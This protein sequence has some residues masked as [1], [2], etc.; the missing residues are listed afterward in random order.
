MDLTLTEDQELVQRTA[1]EFL[2]SRCTMAHVREMEEDPKGYSPE[3]WK[4]MVELGWMGLALPEEYGG[5]GAGFLEVCLL[6]E[7]MGRC[8]LPSPFVPTVACCGMAVARFGTEDQKGA[9]LGAIARGRVMTYARA[10]PHGR[11]AS[12]G[13][14]VSA[15]ETDGGFVLEGTAL[16]VPYAHV[17]ADLLVV[18]QRAG[19][20]EVTVFLVDA[21]STGVT[22]EPLDVVGA[23]R[24]CRVGFSGV[25]VPGDRVL[26]GADGGR[27]VVGAIDAYGAAATCAEMVGGAGRVLDMTVEYATQREQFGRPIG[28]FQAVQHHCA[29]MAMDVTCSRFIT[30]EA[31]WRLSEGLDAARE[32]AMAK[33]WVSEAYERVCAVG[34]QVHGAIGFTLEHDL[35]FFSRHATAAALTFGDGDF[36]WDRVARELGL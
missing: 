33:A 1:R 12:V 11:W 22:C 14:D 27:A 32:V 25:G 15:T 9:W 28:S 29:D 3:L 8:Q 19:D 18:A 31:I 2:E 16:F 10:A 21:A 23:D 26:G 20:G 24:L 5:V 4:E 34:H 30:Y 17:A 36:H 13:A 7:E 6:V 35:R